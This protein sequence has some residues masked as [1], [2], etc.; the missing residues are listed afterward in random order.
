[1]ALRWIVEVR[2]PTARPERGAD[3]D[4]RGARELLCLHDGDE[5]VEPAGENAFVRPGDAM[6]HGERRL[7]R[8][9]REELALHGVGQRDAEVNAEG[10]AVACEVGELLARR[11][12]GGAF[13]AREDDRLHELGHGELGAQARGGGLKGGDTRHVEILPAARVELGHL[14]LDRAV[15]AR[16]AGVQAHD[17]VAERVVGRDGG[18][19]LFEVHAGGAAHLGAGLGARGERDRHEAAGVEDE[20]GLLQQL[21]SAH[22]DQVGIA[23]PGADDGDLRAG[24]QPAVER[25]GEG[26]VA[27]TERGEL[28]CSR[29][30]A[31]EAK[32]KPDPLMLQQILDELK[33]PAHRA[34]MVG[35]S[36]H[37]LAMARA[38]G[39]DSIGVTWGVH[40]RALLEQHQPVAIVDSVPDLH[41]HLNARRLS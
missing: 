18:D 27:E 15:E 29:R 9:V 19:L 6:E 33:L 10:G 22:A 35:D 30:G 21:A 23:R 39:M 3:D 17:G 13:A 2:A 26:V 25:G 31:D 8:I 37:D 28:F 4:Q 20:I 40:D 32:S 24:A 7:R 1:M 14:L 41:L 38:I 16:I 12:R 34:V 11:H 5:F 36:V